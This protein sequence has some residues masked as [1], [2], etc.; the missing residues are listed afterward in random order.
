MPQYNGR[1][2][3][4]WVTDVTALKKSD[5]LPRA[6]EIARGCMEA[7]IA[8]ALQNPANVMEFYV[9]QLVIIQHKQKDY[10]GEVETIERWLGLELTPPRDD[11]RLNLQKRLAKAHELLAKQRGEDPGNYHT[12]WKH[13]VELEKAMKAERQGASLASSTGKSAAAG[14]TAYARSRRVTPWAAPDEILSSP[15]FVAVDFETANRR[16]GVSACQIALVRIDSGQVV[17]RACTYIKPPPGFDKFEFTS[18]H[19][20]S[21]R[22]VAN[23]PLW[24]EIAAWVAAFHGGLPV[25]AHNA[26]FDAGVWSDLD[27]YFGTQTF[28][29]IFFCSY[30]TAQRIVPGLENYKL[31]TVTSALVPEF[32]LNHHRADSDAE[33]C[34]L[35]VAALQNLR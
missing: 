33:A 25:Y 29:E 22:D 1:D 34:A 24:P 12:L 16:G 26:P 5:D 10:S 28:P 31:P 19:G 7:M 21:A 4:D 13:F 15:S 35:V 30:R 20:I 11:Y 9:V 18:K 6:R 32:K 2:I 27:S 23:A 14:E 3:C 17:D 8:A